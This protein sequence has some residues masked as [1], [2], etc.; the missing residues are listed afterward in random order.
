MGRGDPCF[1]VQRSELQDIQSEYTK[2]NKI[3]QPGD[4]IRVP[5]VEQVGQLWEHSVRVSK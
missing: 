2:S 4:Q 5:T 3:W 1:T